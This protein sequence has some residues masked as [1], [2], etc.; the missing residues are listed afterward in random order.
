MKKHIAIQQDD[1]DMNYEY[2]TK[3]LAEKTKIQSIKNA[4]QTNDLS[5]VLNNNVW[6]M[7]KC[8]SDRVHDCVIKE[9]LRF[10]PEYIYLYHIKIA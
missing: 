10:Y 5:I 4:Y 8:T 7:E 9:M 1:Y 3:E 6:Y 2:I